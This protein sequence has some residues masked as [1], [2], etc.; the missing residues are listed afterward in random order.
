MKTL[1]TTLAILIS[2]TVYGQVPVMTGKYAIHSNE[3][4]G[5]WK[6]EI[7]P[8]LTTASIQ[9]PVTTASINPKDCIQC[10]TITLTAQ[11]IRGL[12]TN[13]VTLISGFTGSWIVPV[14]VL[15]VYM[16]GGAPFIP[17]VA[18]PPT[19][20]LYGI[21]LSYHVTGGQ[22]LFGNTNTNGL[23]Q[24]QDKTSIFSPYLNDMDV[25]GMGSDLILSATN[26]DPNFGN[27]KLVISILY[28]YAFP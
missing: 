21:H 27:G 4:G 10:T 9:I 5:T 1:L 22:T 20:P 25:Y 15:Q 13:P 17:M 8:D 6:A 18:Y 19:S 28:R 3:Q 12:E 16:F 26:I 2:L 14:N 24:L 7:M 23:G 11:Q